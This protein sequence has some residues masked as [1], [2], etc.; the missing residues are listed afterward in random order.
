MTTVPQVNAY[1]GDIP[2]KETMDK[3][4]F[5]KA[6]HP[7]LNFMNASYV[8]DLEAHRTALNS[9]SGEF[10]DLVAVSSTTN[11]KGAWN[12]TTTYG[13]G[14]VVEDGSNYFVSQQAGN[15]NHATTDTSWWKPS[16]IT[17]NS[18]FYTKDEIDTMSSEVVIN[19]ASDADLTLTDAQN[20]YGLLRLTD[21]G[22]LLTATRNVIVSTDKRQ[23]IAYNDTAQILT[24][25]TDTG[26]GIAIPPDQFGVL[27]SDGTN[28][29]EQTT[30]SS[31]TTGVEY[32]DNTL[33]GTPDTGFSSTGSRLYPDGTIIGKSSNGISI[34]YP[35]GKR[36][37]FNTITT[38]SSSTLANVF[39]T[40]SG[41]S[42]Y[43]SDTIT[44]PTPFISVPATTLGQSRVASQIASPTVSGCNLR[45]YQ[46]S[47]FT[48]ETIYYIAI[49][50]WK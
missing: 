32:T 11:Y 13:L 12:S 28:V 43:S 36:I 3:I 21:T 10:N 42:N 41:T 24:I 27:Y 2:N 39:G 4:T 40:T 15:L 45:M 35:N 46:G 37:C 47:A 7:Y 18:G 16:Y 34:T 23:I 8:T 38:S 49:G 17:N 48:D 50:D 5:A 22:V 44:Y 6:V 20:D 30:G 19:F 1:G 31:S 33:T 14:E 9:L 26:T 25:K 29:I